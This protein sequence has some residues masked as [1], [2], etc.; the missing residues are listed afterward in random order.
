MSQI[1]SLSH[2]TNNTDE[3]IAITISWQL[4]NKKWRRRSKTVES[5]N[6]NS[7]WMNND[8]QQNWLYE[9]KNGFENTESSLQMFH[10]L[11]SN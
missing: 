3:V 11:Y 5:G 8:Q 2:T 7:E 6:A 1:K 9:L 10:I 4:E